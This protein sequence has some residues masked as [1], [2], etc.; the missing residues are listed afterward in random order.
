MGR[1]G[2]CNK[3]DVGVRGRVVE[4]AGG[5]HGAFG[6]RKGGGPL[7]GP[8]Y[9]RAALG[10]ALQAVCERPHYLGRRRDE[11]AVKVEKAKE[12]LQVSYCGR[13]WK[14]VDGV[15]AARER[16]NAGGGH[17]VPQE[18]DRLLAK[19]TFAG[20]EHQA[21]VAENLEDGGEAEAVS[22]GVW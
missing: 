9:R 22:G 8:L 2:V 10:A 19:A 13:P 12:T 4:D 1:G 7:A 18:F 5:G 3:G 20:V 17:N 14:G 15:D 6:R 16:R 21:V 11:A